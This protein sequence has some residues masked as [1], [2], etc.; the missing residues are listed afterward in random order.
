MK[1]I[2]S[3]VLLAT[4]FLLHG[5]VSAREEVSVAT[6]GSR[7]IY[8][9]TGRDIVSHGHPMNGVVAFRI[10]R[11]AQ[12]Q[13]EWKQIATVDAPDT[14]AVFEQRLQQVSPNAPDPYA[15]NHLPVGK[16]WETI[17]KYRNLDSL[18]SWSG[19]LIVRL[20]LGITYLDTT[21]ERETVYVYRV[22]SIDASGA[23][24]E[25]VASNPVMYP[26][27][28]QLAPLTL[29]DKSATEK[30][31]VLRWRIGKGIQPLNFLVMRKDGRDAFQMIDPVHVLARSHDTT[32]FLVEDTVVLPMHV[33]QY[34]VATA[35]Y[36][37]G[38]GAHSDTVSV[39]EYDFRSIPLPDHLDATGFDS[40]GGV[41]LSW[42]LQEPKFVKTVQIWRSESWDTGYKKIA[43]VSSKDSTFIDRMAVPMVRYF[44]KFIMV[45]QFDE[46]SVPSARVFGLYKST[47]IP[48]GPGEIHAEGRKD[49][50][51]LEWKSKER[52]VLG[53]YVYRTDGFDDTLHLI[54]SLI[55]ADTVVTFLDTSSSLSG[56][57]RYG[58][59][60]RTENTSH[61]MSGF[62]ETL[63]VRPLI[64]TQPPTPLNLATSVHG[65]VI[66]LYWD[67]MR[68]MDHSVS[69]YF[70]YRREASGTAKQNEFKKLSDTLLRAK[71]NNYVDTTVE[72]D[73]IYEY[74]VQAVDYFGGMSGMSASAKGEIQSLAIAPPAG[75][76]AQSTPDGIAMNWDTTHEANVTGFKVYRYERG[77]KPQMMA[78]TTLD[79]REYTDTKAQKGRLYFYYITAV[80]AHEK[81]SAPCDEISI[82]R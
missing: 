42:H 43:D 24:R 52:N 44:Y 79:D 75:L 7:G 61:L 8:V 82:R 69:G 60:I 45:G 55:P 18:H 80:G 56:K 34:Y 5:E 73:K 36:Y 50:V 58:Y 17:E 51:K 29:F 65:H 13:T 15:I 81:E 1:K 21:A 47:L 70:I 39:L 41:R 11:K 63:Y 30:K 14:L 28:P 3:F 27:V 20:A 64:P 71:H 59:A 19:V 12:N 76:R 77:K 32:L 25:S 57:L 53:Y 40:S 49:G 10:E 35:D 26:S 68:A 78:T 74:A 37:G 33:Y 72:T 23:V 22:S 54:T 66:Q 16:L 2:F 31:V 9:V 4:L 38:E 62:A 6:G 67:D 46:L 48:T